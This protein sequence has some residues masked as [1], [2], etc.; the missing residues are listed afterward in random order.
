MTRSNEIKPDDEATRKAVPNPPN[1][2]LLF[3]LSRRL[4]LQP[5]WKAAA[6]CLH[7]SGVYFLSTKYNSVAMLKEKSP[8]AGS[9]YKGY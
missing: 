9:L 5:V 4:L 2:S 8:T 3:I 6:C 7:A 1:W